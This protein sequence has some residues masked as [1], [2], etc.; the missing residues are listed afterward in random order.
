[1]QNCCISFFSQCSY[2]S[3]PGKVHLACSTH[4]CIKLS[5]S[6]PV[7]WYIAERSSYLNFERVKVGYNDFQSF[8]KR[9]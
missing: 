3:S 6:S 9:S 4:N 2:C 8:A 7:R 1:Y 5:S